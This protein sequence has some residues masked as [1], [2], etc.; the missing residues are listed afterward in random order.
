MAELPPFLTPST[1]KY[2]YWTLQNLFQLYQGLLHSSPILTKSVTSGVIA[3]AGSS[4]SQFVSVGEV[5]LKISRSFLIFG[6]LITGPV[7]HYLYIT[8]DKL[9]PRPGVITTILKVL[10]DRALFSPAFLTLTLYLLS[11]LQGKKHQE[12]LDITNETFLSSLFA[13][14]KIWTVPQII[15]IN[16]VPVQYRVLFANLVA[17]IWNFYLSTSKKRVIN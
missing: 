2:S 15:N 8:L 5:S 13:N 11:R 3:C 4:L 10:V 6:T 7:T 16:L 9:F 14:W 12:A 17:L 1:S